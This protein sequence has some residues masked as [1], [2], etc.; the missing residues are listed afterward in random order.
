MS[1]STLQVSKS[2]LQA[3]RILLYWPVL[4]S[5]L[6]GQKCLGLM[7]S[8]ELLLLLLMM[9]LKFF[10]TF[11]FDVTFVME[12]VVRR[13]VRACYFTLFL[14]AVEACDVLA[15]FDNV[16]GLVAIGVHVEAVAP[17]LAAIV[18]VPLDLL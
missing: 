2:T 15:I 3:C 12:D 6:V 11:P 9:M 4:K 13:A 7:R 14:V 8:E 5:Q 1:K 10:V 16:V 18:D 17:D